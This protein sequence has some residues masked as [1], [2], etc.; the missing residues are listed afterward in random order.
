MTFKE[1]LAEMNKILTGANWGEIYFDIYIGGLFRACGY[2]NELWR[3]HSL[4]NLKCFCFTFNAV[5]YNVRIE[6]GE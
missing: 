3:Y 2:Y 1:G 6:L 4:F 5:N